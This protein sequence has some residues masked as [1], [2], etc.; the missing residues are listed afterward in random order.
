MAPR[1]R[2]TM[3]NGDVIPG[4]GEFKMNPGQTMI[5]ETPGGGGFGDP[6]SR[7]AQAVEADLGNNLISAQFA[8]NN[9]RF[10]G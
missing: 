4:K 9:Y 3:N 10:R 7:D 5:V 8:R 1:E 6:S 2:I